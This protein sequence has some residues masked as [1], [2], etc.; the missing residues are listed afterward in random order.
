MFYVVMKNTIIEYCLCIFHHENQF[1]HV[2][3]N[4]WCCHNINNVKLMKYEP[5]LPIKKVHIFY[6]YLILNENFSSTI[7]LSTLHIE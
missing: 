6:T 2:C 7:F 3:E 4:D 5:E 1:I